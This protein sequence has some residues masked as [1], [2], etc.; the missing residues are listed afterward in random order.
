M[1]EPDSSPDANFILPL[2]AWLTLSVLILGIPALRFPL[3]ANYPRPAES[4]ALHVFL[5]SEFLLSALLFP[6]L[7]RNLRFSLLI[8]LVTCPFVFLAAFLAFIP[9]SRAAL[10]AIDLTLWLLALRLFRSLLTSPRARLAGI[11]IAS[12]VVLGGPL[13][14]YLSAEF[15]AGIP[16]FRGAACL[17]PIP[18]ALAL[19]HEPNISITPWLFTLLCW[20][21]LLPAVAIDRRTR[22]S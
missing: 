3:S 9:A 22:I 18:G 16:S 5:V 7:L 14:W 11:A 13:I 20:A 1:T 6:I 8:V 12:A 21:V 4:M 2:A 10:C 17:G 15:A 19:I